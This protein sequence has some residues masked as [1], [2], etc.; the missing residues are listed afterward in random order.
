[1]TAVST[2]ATTVEQ[3]QEMTF[4]ALTVTLIILKKIMSVTETQ[5]NQ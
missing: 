1:M 5:T 2:S 4:A 3:P